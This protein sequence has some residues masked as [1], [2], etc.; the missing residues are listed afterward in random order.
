MEQRLLNERCR[1]ICVCT[2]T[3]LREIN[4]AVGDD[5]RENLPPVSSLGVGGATRRQRLHLYGKRCVIDNDRVVTSGCGTIT[6][7]TALR[8]GLLLAG[9]LEQVSKTNTDIF[10]GVKKKHATN[11]DDKATQC[12]NNVLHC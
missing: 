3:Q 8:R 7:P 6:T 12:T 10:E 5:G 2:V 1:F 11:D 4:V 9:H